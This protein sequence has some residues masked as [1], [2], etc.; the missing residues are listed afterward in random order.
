MKLYEL[1]KYVNQ[2]PESTK[3]WYSIAKDLG[4]NNAKLSSYIGSSVQVH[5]TLQ[6]GD[7]GKLELTDKGREFLELVEYAEKWLG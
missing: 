1:L 3:N 6:D 5:G 2:N 4:T 7:G